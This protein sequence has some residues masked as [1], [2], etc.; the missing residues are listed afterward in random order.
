[1]ESLPFLEF[2]TSRDILRQNL[3][4]SN[5]ETALSGELNIFNSCCITENPRLDY[6]V[7]IFGKSILIRLSE[8]LNLFES[9]FCYTTPWAYLQGF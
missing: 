3:K 7:V 9:L 2:E 1:M 5:L 4:I 8:K 6:H